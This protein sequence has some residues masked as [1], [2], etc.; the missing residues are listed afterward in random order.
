MRRYMAALIDDANTIPL[1]VGANLAAVGW[2]IFDMFVRT[3]FWLD[4]AVLGSVVL[5]EPLWI[6]LLRRRAAA[7]EKRGVPRRIL[8]SIAHA[9]KL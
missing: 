3:S 9:L 5:L 4:V 6:D 7:I 2:A 8:L 1:F